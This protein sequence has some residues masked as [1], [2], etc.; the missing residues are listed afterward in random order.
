VDLPHP[1]MDKNI[2][3]VYQFNTLGALA[4]FNDKGEWDEE[5][6]QKNSRFH[7]S[8]WSSLFQTVTS[9]NSITNNQ[10]DPDG[11]V[12]FKKSFEYFINFV[13]TA[14]IQYDEL[15]KKYGN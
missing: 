9:I 1:E 2:P 8:L 7:Q 11:N 6:L 4:T 5:Y 3:C 14:L 15:Y 13:Y 10:I 12:D